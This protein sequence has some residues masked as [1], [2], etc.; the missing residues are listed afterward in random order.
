MAQDRRHGGTAQFFDLAAED[1]HEALGRMFGELQRGFLGPGGL[2]E[3]H[4]AGQMQRLFDP[5]A[6]GFGRCMG[7]CLCVQLEGAHPSERI[8]PFPQQHAETRTHPG[9]QVWGV[10]L[11]LGQA[12]S[13]HPGRQL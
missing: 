5:G 8:Y 9:R 13:R 7:L 4:L 11:E 12:P 10:L 2:F 3:R 6:G 1:P